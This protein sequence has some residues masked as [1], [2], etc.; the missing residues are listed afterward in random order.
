M[1]LSQVMAASSESEMIPL[2]EFSED[3]VFDS[4]KEAVN[5]ALMNQ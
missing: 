3:C 1:Q 4:W 2:F 5:F